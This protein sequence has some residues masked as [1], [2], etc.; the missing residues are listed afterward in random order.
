MRQAANWMGRTTSKWK[1]D[2]G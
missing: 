1:R 2:E